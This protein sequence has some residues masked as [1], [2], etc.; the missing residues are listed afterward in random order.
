MGIKIKKQREKKFRLYR[1]SV[2][3]LF[4]AFLCFMLFSLQVCFNYS[5]C[6]Q[7][8]KAISFISYQNITAL[9]LVGTLTLLLML[10]T[11]FINE[12]D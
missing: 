4:V 12:V 7:T 8:V 10:K 11:L 6:S 2:K 9:M 1:A 3:V 5:E